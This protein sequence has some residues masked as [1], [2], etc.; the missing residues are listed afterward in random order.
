MTI[1]RD[2]VRDRLHEAIGK[3]AA[4]LERFG[5]YLAKVKNYRE[6][7][8]IEAIR[9]HLMQKHGWLPSEVRSLSTDDLQ[10]AI[11]EEMSGWTVN[12]RP[13]IGTLNAD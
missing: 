8:G 4:M 1:E 7:D 10:F 13:P 11:S 12:S 3:Q 2:E 9:Y 5:D 6:H